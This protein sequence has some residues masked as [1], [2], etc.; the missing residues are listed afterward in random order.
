MNAGSLTSL[1]ERAD[2]SATDLRAPPNLPSNLPSLQVRRV[3]RLNIGL[4]IPTLHAGGAQRVCSL[5]SSQWARSGHHVTLMTFTDPSSDAFAVSPF[6]NR[7]VLGAADSSAGV[8]RKAAKNAARLRSV[9]SELVGC[10]LDVAVSFNSLSTSLL[11]LAGRGLPTVCIGAEHKHTCVRPL[12]T[13]AEWARWRSYGWLDAVVGPTDD[14]ARWL[15]Q[16]THAKL[17]A[18]IPNPVEVPL[19]SSKPY[20][21]PGSLLR[22]G[23]RLLLA[24]GNLTAEKNHDHL[25]RAFVQACETLPS[26]SAQM[27]WQLVV[28]GEGPQR[29]VLEALIKQL[30]VQDRVLLPGRAGNVADWYAA[31]DAFAMAS[32]FAGCPNSL[33]EALAYGVPSVVCD[34]LSAGPHALIRDGVNGLLAKPNSAADLATALGRVMS[35]AALRERLAQHAEITN[36]AHGIEGISQQWEAVFAQAMAVRGFA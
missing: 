10:D 8:W 16:N 27:P 13:L 2:S 24:V 34:G 32:L 4:L 5:L 14:S 23:S 29:P 9:R 15:R 11:V 28:I 12:P 6:V 26:Q 7:V 20:R 35:D 25:I 22:P 19:P 21:Q 3:R 31:A 30:G 18:A 33:L 1:F 17:V 36:H